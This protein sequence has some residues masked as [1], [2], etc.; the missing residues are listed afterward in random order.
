M[1]HKIHCR[2]GVRPQ[3]WREVSSRRFNRSLKSVLAICPHRPKV[4]MAQEYRHK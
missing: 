3:G 4:G 1:R 2:R